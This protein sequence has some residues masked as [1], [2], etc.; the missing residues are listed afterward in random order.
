M[1]SVEDEESKKIAVLINIAERQAALEVCG[2]LGFT[3]E[4]TP[5]TNEIKPKALGMKGVDVDFDAIEKSDRQGDV[6]PKDNSCKMSSKR[7]NLSGAAE[8]ANAQY[9][10]TVQDG[11][12]GEGDEFIKLDVG[13]GQDFQ[14]LNYNHKLRRKLRRAIDNA[15]VR[16]ELLIRDRAIQYLK[17]KGEVVPPVLLSPSKPLNVKGH[18]IL[19]N[20]KLETS[21][22]ERVRSRMELTEFNMQMKI[23]RRQAKDAAIYAGLKKHA[24]LMGRI[25]K[26]A[27]EGGAEDL[28]ISDTLQVNG[29]HVSGS[30][31]QGQSSGRK[32]S[33]SN[34]EIET[35]IDEEPPQEDSDATSMSEDSSDSA[36]S[37]P[38]AVSGN[39]AK[40]RKK[41]NEKKG[42]K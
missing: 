5:G 33:L 15:E 25:E 36:R 10:S 6:R 29:N 7:V 17:E 21:K 41:A 19:D 34:S 14:M 8:D 4:N 16:K 32:R 1:K 42:S 39:P 31:L 40:R 12:H 26:S 22:Q 2:S 37:D 11:T 13:D 3:I 20:G 18:R 30:S 35:S 38:S 9:V 28:G 27:K 23:L 24:E